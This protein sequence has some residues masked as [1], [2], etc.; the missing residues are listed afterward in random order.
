MCLL[1]KRPGRGNRSRNYKDDGEPHDSGHL[2]VPGSTW[3]DADGAT[4]ALDTWRGIQ[5]ELEVLAS[6]TAC[7]QKVRK[8][9]G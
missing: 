9:N 1:A 6:V 2:H 4:S 5:A 7:L 8:G 3:K